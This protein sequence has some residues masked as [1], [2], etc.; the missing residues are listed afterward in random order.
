MF[1][2]RGDHVR[3]RW[4]AREVG[5]RSIERET[6]N[7]EGQQPKRS[8]PFVFSPIDADEQTIGL[9]SGHTWQNRENRNDKRCDCAWEFHIKYSRTGAVRSEHSRTSIDQEDP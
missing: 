6:D 8:L 2:L 4:R 3:W 1:E 9:L 5:N 7:T